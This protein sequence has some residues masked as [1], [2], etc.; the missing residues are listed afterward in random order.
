[1]NTPNEGIPS[2]EAQ[3]LPNTPPVTGQPAVTPPASAEPA[4]APQIPAE[5]QARID[6]AEARAN[7]LEKQA[8]YHQS[9]ADQAANQVQAL[10]GNARPADPLQPYLERVSQALSLDPNSAEAKYLAQ[11]E[12]AN[13]QR[14]QQLS[15]GLMA[16]QQV[17]QVMQQVYATAPHLFQNPTVVSEMQNALNQAAAK[18]DLANVNP[19]YARAVGAIAFDAA[20][21]S[22]PQNT[23]RQTPPQIP[24]F[25]SQ[26]GPISGFSQPPTMTAGKP[27]VAPHLAQAAQAEADAVR[28]RFNLPKQ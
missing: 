15:G 6:A 8:R 13:D 14:Y 2:A 22:Q 27:G 17:P 7:E 18:G 3:V 23:Q 19:G 9:R 16:Q 24:Q 5:V 10:V 26:F 28:A 4:A 1:M 25:N 12:M 11:S 21:Y 20:M